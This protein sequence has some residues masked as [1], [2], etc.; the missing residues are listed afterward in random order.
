MSVPLM[1]LILERTLSRPSSSS[2]SLKIYTIENDD[3]DLECMRELRLAVDDSSLTSQGNR[4]INLPL[5]T[6]GLGNQIN[7]K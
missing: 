3:N 5:Q 2:K 6:R 4:R 1:L 7:E